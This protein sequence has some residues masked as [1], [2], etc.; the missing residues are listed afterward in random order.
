MIRKTR[1]TKTE[2]INERQFI[3]SPKIHHLK[4]S[5]TPTIGFKA[6]NDFHFSPMTELLKPTGVMYNPNCM[7]KGMMYRKSRYLTFTA[8]RY[9]PTPK[10]HI[11]AS[12][13]KMGKK[14][15]CQEGKY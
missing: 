12:K 1:I 8:V 15:I 7:M 13:I 14:T 9:N 5:I 3:G 6:Y 2:K 10:A 4:P 11:N